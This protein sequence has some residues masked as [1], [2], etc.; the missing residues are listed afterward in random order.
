MRSCPI[1]FQ[2]AVSELWNVNILM[3]T[4]LT[5]FYPPPPQAVV[6]K[7][8]NLKPP[9]LIVDTIIV[10][11]LTRQFF[12]IQV[13]QHS[14][15]VNLFTESDNSRIYCLCQSAEIVYVLIYFNFRFL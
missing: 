12:L 15:T 4:L 2:L 5:A 11:E 13:K 7:L 10:A 9:L 14:Y 8:E 3:K 1:S 6:L